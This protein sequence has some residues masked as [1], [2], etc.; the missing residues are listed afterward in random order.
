MDKATVDAYNKAAPVYA[1]KFDTIGSRVGDVERGIK[2]A[3]KENPFVVELGCGNGRDAFDIVA[4]TDRYIGVDVSESMIALAKAKLPEADFVVSDMLEYKIPKGVD[5]VFAFASF[6]HLERHEVEQV[7]ENIHAKMADNGI[8]YIS[9]KHDDYQ[10]RTKED[11]FGTRTY[12]FYRES[13]FDQM[14]KDK[15]EKVYVDTHT[16]RGVDWI[17]VALRKK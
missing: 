11:E 16:I 6:L 9:T 5:L 2:L 8:V 3:G 14:L 12:F 17:V 10:T 15:W 7:L 4:R 13:D 1:A